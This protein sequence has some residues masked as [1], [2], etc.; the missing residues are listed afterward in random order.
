VKSNAHGGGAFGLLRR[1]FRVAGKPESARCAPP[2]SHRLLGRR[3]GALVPR[4]ARAH[5]HAD[6]DQLDD[7]LLTLPELG[8][9][10]PIRL[11]IPRVLSCTCG[12]MAA[13]NFGRTTSL[14]HDELLLTSSSGPP[15]GT[16]C[17]PQRANCPYPR[18]TVSGGPFLAPTCTL[19]A[20]QLR[21]AASGHTSPGTHALDSPMAAYHVLPELFIK[22]EALAERKRSRE[23]AASGKSAKRQVG[24]PA[25]PACTTCPACTG[26]SP[27][28]RQPSGQTSALRR[29]V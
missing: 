4:W 15:P 12:A 24:G 25:R 28:D 10:T 6:L 3:L 14:P 22:Q 9:L 23:D 17:A 20:A 18:P 2:L 16:G 21:A 1:T 8:A 26:S 11:P 29:R 5:A 27:R 13:A 7:D 19:T